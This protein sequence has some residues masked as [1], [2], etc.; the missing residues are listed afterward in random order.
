MDNKI[1][2]PRSYDLR[3]G[4]ETTQV[5]RSE[6]PLRLILLQNIRT[7][8]GGGVSRNGKFRIG[9]FTTTAA[10]ADF[11]G[12]THKINLVNDSRLWPLGLVWTV[13]FLARA[14]TLTGDHYILGGS[15]ANA[16]LRIKQTSASTLV[17][18][19]RDSATTETTLTLTG[20]AVSTIIG[21]QVIRNRGGLTLKANGSSTTGTMSATLLLDAQGTPVIGAHNATDFYDG[22]IEFVRGFSSVRANQQDGW[23]RLLN[24][25]TPSVLFDYV[26]E[27]DANNY[28]IDRGS[29]GLHGAAQAG[30]ASGGATIADNHAP[31]LGIGVAGD[32]DVMRK[33]YVRVGDRVY[34][35]TY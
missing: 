29:L 21:G 7:D 33:L 32:Q 24:P 8:R 14:D 26:C 20:M 9:R 10:V 3:R 15:G 18:V 5:D 22:R 35:A 1:N 19:V 23:A 11:N 30:L 25:R 6:D 12:T 13:E 17:V 2:K 27:V 31:V 34:P 16:G 4:M 28:V